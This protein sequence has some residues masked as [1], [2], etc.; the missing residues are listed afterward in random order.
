MSQSALVGTSV[1]KNHRLW[2]HGC[3]PHR[4]S[5]VRVYTLW[6]GLSSSGESLVTMEQQYAMGICGSG[7]WALYVS[8][9][10]DKIIDHR[11][12]VLG[13]KY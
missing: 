6:W 8:L 5:C 7:L 2:S 1:N 11:F 9:T 12:I 4:D 3:W 10:F 13:E